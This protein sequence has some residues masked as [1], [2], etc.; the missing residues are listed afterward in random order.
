MTLAED[1]SAQKVNGRSGQKIISPQEQSIKNQKRQN[2][3][4]V[5]ETVWQVL[6][7]AAQVTGQSST[8]P[9]VKKIATA[10]Y[11]GLVVTDNIDDSIKKTNDQIYGTR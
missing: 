11:T 1:A 8:N 4:V 9:N 2:R 10:V 6:G 3:Q 7:T 5:Q